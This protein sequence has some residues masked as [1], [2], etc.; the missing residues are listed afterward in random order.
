[1]VIRWVQACIG[2]CLLS[3]YFFLK[4][5]QARR[6][7]VATIFSCACALQAAHA[8]RYDG[9]KPASVM[10]HSAP[11]CPFSPGAAHVRLWWLVD[12][13]MSSLPFF[14]P[15]ARKYASV[16]DVCEMFILVLVF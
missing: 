8:H 11:T 1:M 10:S 6:A 14:S 3:Y 4:I 9:Q 2:N 15:A 12:S 7:D 5:L 16:L 13:F